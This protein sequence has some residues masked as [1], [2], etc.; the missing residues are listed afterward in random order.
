MKLEVNDLIDRSADV[1]FAVSGYATGGHI[2][3]VDQLLK[4]G[5]SK[6]AAIQGYQSGGYVN[7]LKQFT[8]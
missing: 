2:E 3:Q 8:Q 6:E 4:Q 5:A 1:D 7:F